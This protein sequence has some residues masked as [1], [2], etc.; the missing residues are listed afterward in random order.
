MADND[1]LIELLAFETALDEYPH[2]REMYDHLMDEHF[3][4]PTGEECGI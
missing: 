4:T 2:L 1:V 3:M